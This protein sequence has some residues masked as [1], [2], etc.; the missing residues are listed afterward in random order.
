MESG[1]M[2]CAG[3]GADN[4]GWANYCPHCGLSLRWEHRDL[5]IPLGLTTR[6]LPL[7]SETR[8][9]FDQLVREELRRA[10]ETGWQADGPIDWRSLTEA[11]R[12]RWRSH[13]GVGGHYLLDAVIVRV[14][15]P[16]P[17]HALEEAAP[18]ASD[19]PLPAA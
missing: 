10:A 15:R 14:R 7:E 8:R 9:R 4:P 12:F 13:A 11:S 18:I 5:V 1:R 17:G 19:S 2:A 6:D 3:C 16:I